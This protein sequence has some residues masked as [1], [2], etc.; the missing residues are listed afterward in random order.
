MKRSSLVTVALGAGVAG[1]LWVRS[2]KK[3]KKA[4]K[5]TVRA[6]VD[7]PIATVFDYIVPVNLMRIFRGTTLI[8]A[9]VDTSIKEGWNKPG[10]IRT[11]TFADGTTSQ[12]S[13]LTVLPPTSFS[14]KNEHFTS[15][16]LRLLLQQLDGEWHF[17]EPRS[18]QTAIEWT[19]RAIPLNKFTRGLVQLVLVPQLHTMLTNA[20]RILQDDLIEAR[21]TEVVS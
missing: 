2:S 3:D 10:L 12:E 4:P 19:Y 6:T 11:I 17:T 14:Y 13:L 5:I 1:F 15:L 16:P 7:A 20:L 8:P 18:G 21:N 9:I